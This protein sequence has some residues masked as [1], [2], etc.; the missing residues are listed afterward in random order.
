MAEEPT[1][2]SIS[3][4]PVEATENHGSDLY[5]VTV[6][7]GDGTF[8]TAYKEHDTLVDGL[9]LDTDLD[10]HTTDTNNPH[11]VTAAQVGAPTTSDFTSHTGNNSIHRQINDAST[12]ATALWSADKISTELSG[13]ANTSHTHTASAITDFETAVEAT[14]DVAANTAARHTH[15]NK[16]TLDAT[17]ASFTTSLK[18]K[19]DGIAT[20]ATAN[21][22]DA[23]LKNRANHTGT[24]PLSTISDVTASAAEVNKLDGVTASTAELNYV[25]GVTSSIQSQLDGKAASSHTH[26]ASQITNF[27][28]AADARITA[29]KGQNNGL[30][31]LDGSGKV[32]STQLPS[33]VDDVL[34]YDDTDAF[35][36]T[37]TAGIIYLAKDTNK[38]YRWGGSAYTEISPSPGSTDAVPEGSTNLYY[39]DERVEANS[40]VAANTAARHSHSNKTV[41]DNT[42]ASFT[43][44]LKNKLDGIAAGAEVNVQSDWNQSTTSADDYIKNKPTLGTAAAADTGDFATAAQGELADSAVQPDDLGDLATKDKVGVSDIDATGSPSSSTYLKGDGSWG[45]VE[46][47]DSL[48]DQTGNS[49]K[50]LT[51]DGTDASWG[52]I[53]TG[54]LGNVVEDTTPQ[55]GGD[56]DLN[57]HKVGDA[58]AAD[59]TKLHGLTATSTELNYVD[60]VTSA[61]QTQLDGKA[62]SSH[63]HTASQITD[64]DTEVSNNTDVA[65]NTSARH[66][67]VTVA[68]SSEIDFTLTGQQISASLKAGSIDESKLDTSVNASLDLADSATQPGDLSA[69]ATSGDY[70]DLSNTPTIPSDF[71]DLSDGTTNKAFTATE[72]NKLSGIATGAEV[73]V[74]S[75]WSESSSSSD[76]YIKNKPTLGTAAAADTGDFATASQ[77]SK[78]DSAV[79]D[80]T[81]L[82]ITA[83]ASELNVLDGITASTVEL[84]YVDGVTSSV[85]TQLDGKVPTTRTVNGHA[86]TANVTVDAD[87]VLPTQTGNSGKY[88]T[89]NGSTAS[90]ATVSAGS[91][92]TNYFNDY[93]ANQSGLTSS[94]L[95]ALTGSVNGSNTTFTVSDEVYVSGT[96]QVYLN[97]VLQVLGDAI[98]ETTPASGVFDFVTAPASGSQIYVRYATQETTSDSVVVASDLADVATSGAYSDLSGTPTIPDALADL[99]TTVTGSQLNS[100]KSKVDGIASGAEVNTVDSV[101]TQTGAVVLDADD[102]DDTS[103]TNKFVTAADL[104]K[105]GNLSGTNTGDQTDITGNAGTATKLQ[106]ARTIAGQ[107]FDGSA[108]ISIAPTDLTGVTATASELNILDGATLSTTELNY[109]DGVTSS[110]QSQIN[111]KADDDA[112]VHDTGDETVAGTK[113]FSSFPVTPSSA[114]TTDYQVANKK[115]VDDNI[116]SGSGDMLLG[117]AQTV[118]ATKTFNAGTLL[119]K[120]SE[121]FNVK[122]YGAVGDDSTDDTT[123]IQSAINAASSAGGGVVFFPQGTYKITA[124]LALKSFVSL[125]GVGCGSEEKGSTIHQTSTSLSALQGTNTTDVMESITIEQLRIAGPASGTGHGIYLK[126]T[127]D[128]GDHPPFVSFSFR[129]LYVYGFGG[130]GINAESLITSVVERVTCESNGN[131]FLLNGAADGEWSSVNT[132]VTL[133]SCYAN[134]NT[135]VGYKVDHSTYISFI[136]CAADSNG[137]NYLVDTS[138]CVTFVGVG[139]EYAD[140]DSS[141]PGDGW[142]ITGSSQIGLYNCYSYQNDHYSWWITGSST[143][144]TMIGCQDNTN[145]GTNALKIDSGSSVSLLDCAFAGSTSNAGTL[146]NLTADLANKASKASPTFTGTVTLPTGLTGVLRADSGVVSTDSDVT[147]IVSAATASAAGKVELATTAET[148]TGTD[149]TRA[150]TPDG[151]HDMTSLSGAAWF[152][153]EDNMASNSA[154]KT[155]SQQSVKAYVDS[156]LSGK[157]NTSHTQTLSTISDVT[158]SAAEVNVLDGVTATTAE[159]NIMDG[160][161]AT[162]SELNALDGITATVTELNYTDGVTSSIQDQLNDKVETS[163]LS[164]SGVGF[165]DH[166]STAG[167]ARPSEYVCVIW[168]GDVE[169]DNFDDDTDVWIDTSA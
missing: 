31:T 85:Q 8:S 98:T 169:P 139:S 159:L 67:A 88:L 79:Q 130:W 92:D 24:Q 53:S 23:N 110:I 10:A 112:V 128:S 162:A 69:V 118:T 155:V 32:P 25:D 163:T 51:T 97:G 34:E 58:T 115:Y 82:S 48:P 63:T 95:D 102:I 7:N 166:G 107:S 143:G 60:G 5:E 22:T 43:S 105:L 57:S 68:D 9:A 74:Q 77:G 65:A 46:A 11:E 70:D 127:G 16:S 145:L 84:N 142:K 41:L 154:T 149:A 116:G 132:S 160:V 120:G 168:R 73:N 153:D 33:Y 123:A 29:Q 113:T 62:A 39:T 147:D 17:T 167:T 55:L 80:L 104:T 140:P 161:T 49:G 64:F 61:I 114:P 76:A 125:I 148:T 72:K 35:P 83:T 164:A 89:T 42:T 81:D 108:N 13:K 136:T 150:V 19:L 6:D 15:S 131:G 75:D 111:D 109:V 119:D 133:T 78:A 40:D 54:G 45:S 21:D 157:A 158:A 59:L 1:Q 146:V 137:T 71:D 100:L 152:L 165:V 50:Y 94:G 117:T 86:L 37:G 129:D 106:T 99:D 144:V 3:E 4:I 20:G 135:T 56:L 28:T 2:Y 27:N 26:T 138:N 14:T 91:G 134:A 101:N 96:L 18:N 47:G 121:V 151:L 122:A 38:V 90:W 156:G 141:S 126:N 87:D 66:A 52:T 36:A 44:T 103:T 124:A 93:T 12:S 30:A